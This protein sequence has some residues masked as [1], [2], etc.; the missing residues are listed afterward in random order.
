[1]SNTPREDAYDGLI[2]PLMTE[3]RRS[4]PMTKQQRVA[5]LNAFL[6]DGR[7]TRNEWTGK[8]TQGRETACLLAALSPEAGEQRSAEKC[9]AEVMPLWLAHLTP[10]MDDR[11]SAEAWLEMVRRY[12]A[13]A[14]RWHVLGEDAWRRCEIAARKAAVEEA[15]RH[16]PDDD[17]WG[18]REACSG[19]LAWLG[20]EMPEAAA[21][22]AAAWAAEAEAE[23][24]AWAAEAEAAAWAAEAAAD[25]ARAAGADRITDQILSAIEKECDAAEEQP[26]D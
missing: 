14:A 1:M 5:N 9:P 15:L 8:D 21:A 7:L 24:A 16:V 11:G 6:E 4:S 23:A 12:A 18:V 20:S 13:V 17:P 3:T 25:A 2:A 26:D 10:W 19:V 22:G